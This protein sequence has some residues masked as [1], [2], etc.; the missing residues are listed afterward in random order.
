MPYEYENY[1]SSNPIWSAIAII[2]V[3]V[4]VILGLFLLRWKIN[5]ELPERVSVL[6]YNIIDKN[7][8]LCNFFDAVLVNV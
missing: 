8:A 7:N 1:K 4:V 5:Q 2:L 6:L 3:M